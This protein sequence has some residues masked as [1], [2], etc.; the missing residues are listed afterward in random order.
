MIW[1]PVA[2]RIGLRGPIARAAA[3]TEPNRM[4]RRA[5]KPRPV[6]EDRF[7]S[8]TLD[9]L[10][11]GLAKQH[12][13]LFDQA[14]EQLLAFDGVRESVVWHGVPWRWTV[15]IAPAGDPRSPIAY[16]IPQPGRPLVAIP[17]PVEALS[18]I[19][20]RR[21]SKAIRD[22]IV[23]AA[24][25]GGVHWPTWELQSKPLID[26]IVNLLRRRLEASLAPSA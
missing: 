9:D 14:R 1:Y 10:R 11:A 2:H 26:E 7:Q 21:M 12:A 3:V 22:G 4:T 15:T 23:F 25:V 20:L 16:L 8:P 17:L 19:P 5:I 18:S 6:W 24:E 13:Q